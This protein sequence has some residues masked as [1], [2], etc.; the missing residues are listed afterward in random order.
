MCSDNDLSSLRR[1][2]KYLWLYLI[3]AQNPHGEDLTCQKQGDHL[4]MGRGPCKQT[5]LYCQS[6]NS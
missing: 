4:Y 5:S 3:G 6:G 2:P 1:M